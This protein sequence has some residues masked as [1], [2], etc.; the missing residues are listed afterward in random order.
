M[1]RVRQ[2]I[3]S[4]DVAETV[5]TR[6]VVGPCTVNVL[7]GTVWVKPGTSVSVSTGIQITGAIDLVSLGTLAFISDETGAKVQVIAWG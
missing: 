1:D 2:I 3:P 5:V 6:S 7:S 4:F